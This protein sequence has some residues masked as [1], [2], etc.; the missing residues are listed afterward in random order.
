MMEN[1]H[2]EIK[3]VAS[4]EEHKLIT[5]NADELLKEELSEPV[6]VKTKKNINNFSPPG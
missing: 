6:I 2:S 1:D 5:T 4:K 3:I